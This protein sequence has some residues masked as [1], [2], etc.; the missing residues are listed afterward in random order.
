MLKIN[1]LIFYFLEGREYIFLYISTHIP[2]MKE[3]AYADKMIS[4][5]HGWGQ[6]T[7]A[8]HT[9][10]TYS[11][12]LPNHGSACGSPGGNDS[13]PMMTSEACQKIRGNLA[14]TG[15]GWVMDCPDSLTVEAAELLLR[16][17][18]W[19]NVIY[20]HRHC[21]WFLRIELLCSCIALKGSQGTAR[22]IDTFSML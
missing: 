13:W 18:L 11:F 8:I 6:V 3:I 19:N 4:P 7:Q 21:C 12:I 20:Q 17:V 22:I 16:D 9:H 10:I 14:G 2:H 15:H 5:F 1:N